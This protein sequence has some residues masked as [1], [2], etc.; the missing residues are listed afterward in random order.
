MTLALGK[1]LR[2]RLKNDP[3]VIG[4]WVG[5]AHPTVIE[6]MAREGFGFL[7]LDGEHAPIRT[8]ALCTLLPPAELFGTPTV[9]R[10][11]SQSTA[12]MKAALDAGVS[13]LMVPMVESADHARAIV[14]AC[15]YMPLGRRG[16]GPWRASGYYDDFEAY[17][18]EAN[19]ATTL[20]LQ[21]ESA[22]GLANLDEITAVEGYDVLFVG[23]ADLASSLGLRVGEFD[24]P[25]VDVLRQVAERTQQAGK[26][27]AIDAP[28]VSMIPLLSEMGY[29]LFTI[30][31]DIGF[32]QSAGRSL[33][34]EVR[35]MRAGK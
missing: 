27:P 17:L 15:K 4:A 12:E 14:S 6:L 10:V 33:I 3:M 1:L 30:G 35:S 31:S 34:R 20:M 21:L 29:A 25:M 11:P 16:V 22:A 24:G 5:I 2:S 8:S 7:L 26:I 9:F 13:G 28:S 18:A 32:I 19:D 23:P